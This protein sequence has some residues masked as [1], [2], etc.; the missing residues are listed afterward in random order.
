M[1][2]IIVTL[3]GRTKELLP[4]APPAHKWIYGVPAIDS[5]DY[6]SIKTMP[7]FRTLGGRGKYILLQLFYFVQ[8]LAKFNANTGAL[9]NIAKYSALNPPLLPPPQIVF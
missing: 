9:R 1:N 7:T 6:F 5:D 2:I 3:E 8:G 4:V